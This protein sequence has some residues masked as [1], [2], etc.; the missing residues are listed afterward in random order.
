MTLIVAWAAAKRNR[1]TYLAPAVP[2]ALSTLT[3]QQVQNERRN[4]FF[5][6]KVKSHNPARI[7]I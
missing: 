4:I 2:F 7:F 5:G 6:I 3:V 1:W